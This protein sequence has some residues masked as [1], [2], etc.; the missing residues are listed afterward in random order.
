MIQGTYE[1]IGSGVDVGALAQ[2]D[3]AQPR[4]MDGRL[5]TESRSVKQ[6]SAL[7]A[8]TPQP[9]GATSRLKTAWRR[10]GRAWDAILILDF[11]GAWAQARAAEWDIADLPLAEAAS[12]IA[13]IALLQA[14]AYTLCDESIAGLA[15]A[16]QMTARSGASAAV[17]TTICRYAYWRQRDFDALRDLKPPPHPKARRRRTVLPAILDLSIEAAMALEQ[18]RL[19]IARRLARDALTL[20]ETLF[21]R[22]SAATA[23]PASIAAQL[24][25]EDDSLDEA[26][27]LI[28]NRI[29][30][31]QACGDIECAIRT[32]VIM[33][34]VA[35]QR[36]KAD[37]A[38]QILDDASDLAERRGWPRLL[39]AGLL[40]N[41]EIMLSRDRLE[42][43]KRCMSH[44]ELLASNPGPGDYL[45]HNEIRHW[46]LIGRARVE[47]S[48]APSLRLVAVFRR[49]HRDAVSGHQ[50]FHAVKLEVWLADALAAIGQVDEA[51]DT[52]LNALK[53]GVEVGLYRVFLDGGE[54]IQDLLRLLR[55]RLST[56]SDRDKVALYLDSLLSHRAPRPRSPAIKAAS[57]E[58]GSR[59]SER[60]RTIIHLVATGLS[61][62]RI[63]RTL[64]ITPETVKTHIKNLFVKLSVTTRSEAVW[65]AQNLG[66]I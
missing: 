57:S 60:E 66:L 45:A 65:R 4:S 22:N 63:A 32:F 36:G 51:A 56:A 44:L 10:I 27:Q 34:R 59:I 19:P 21:E 48:M 52:L 23:L 9:I 24:A 31:V 17:A 50:L 26:E 1:P 62:K 2:P 64:G 37:I 28:G 7:A 54:T 8:N 15:T 6:P 20:A 12:I 14:T 53:T 49:L 5:G 18:L 29:F 38:A 25:Y 42:D 40:E 33:A 46:A 43:A 39:A 11:A 61:N 41:I 47:R 30:T 58:R 3:R 35:A 16:L 13:A 55:N